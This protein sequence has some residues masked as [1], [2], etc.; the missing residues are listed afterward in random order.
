VEFVFAWLNTSSH[1][2]VL[3][4]GAL[5]AQNGF[6]VVGA[7]S[8]FFGYNNVYLRVRTFLRCSAFSSPVQAGEDAV[9]AEVLANDGGFGG[10]GEVEA[11]NVAGSQSLNVHNF[12]VPGGKTALFQAGL[13]V[14]AYADGDC[15]ASVDFSSGNFQVLCPFVQITFV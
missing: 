7:D 11:E 5:V 3:D 8:T 6:C 4:V 14:T 2:V 13:D 15:S 1:S 10:L 12:V 9:V